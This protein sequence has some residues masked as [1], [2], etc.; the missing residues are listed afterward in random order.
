MSS[1]LAFMPAVD[2]LKAYKQKK[3]SPVEA[4]KAALAQIAKYNEKHNVY[5]FV[6]E[7]GALASARESEQRWQRGEP[8]GLVDGAPASVKDLVIA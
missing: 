8:K 2:L 1:E 4:T 7:A 3:L 6:D 5:C